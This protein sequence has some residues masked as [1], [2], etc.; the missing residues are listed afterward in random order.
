M[1]SNALSPAQ[2]AAKRQAEL[3][4][5]ERELGAF[6]LADRDEGGL[7][8]LLSSLHGDGLSQRG[9]GDESTGAGDVGEFRLSLE[10]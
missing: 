3:E 2:I 1:R 4:A 7:D 5:A 9:F 10:L 8:V 6:G